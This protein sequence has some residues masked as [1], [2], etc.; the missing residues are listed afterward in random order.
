[1]R[2]GPTS[3]LEGRLWIQWPV[4]DLEKTHSSKQLA[5]RLPVCESQKKRSI[6]TLES[7][8]HS[9]HKGSMS[10]AEP[11]A[12]PHL[13]VSFSYLLWFCQVLHDHVLLAGSLDRPERYRLAGEKGTVHDEPGSTLSRDVLFPEARVEEYAFP[14]LLEAPGNRSQPTEHP[15]TIFKSHFLCETHILLLPSISLSHFL[16]SSPFL[17]LTKS[18]QVFSRSVFQNYYHMASAASIY[19]SKLHALFTIFEDIHCFKGSLHKL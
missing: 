3:E 15:W 18:E 16:S 14:R 9:V 4:I 12:S 17:S 6:L 11:R 8:C 5:R 2:S 10:T 7:L 19:L 1:M 13:H